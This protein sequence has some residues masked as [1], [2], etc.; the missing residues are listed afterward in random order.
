M[1][2]RLS[3]LKVASE[4]ASYDHDS[5][6]PVRHAVRHLCWRLDLFESPDVT[7]EAQREGIA[8]GDARRFLD[9]AVSKGF[10]DAEQPSDTSLTS[11]VPDW[12]TC[13]N[14][15]LTVTHPMC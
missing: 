14:A 4:A 6:L 5:G 2:I 10:S 3:N 13:E 8:L 7:P 12:L 11:L 9:N 15:R 1:R